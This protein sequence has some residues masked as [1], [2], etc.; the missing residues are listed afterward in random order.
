[1]NKLLTS[2]S[3]IH[4]IDSTNVFLTNVFLEI[5]SKRLSTKRVQIGGCRQDGCEAV[6]WPARTMLTVQNTNYPFIAHKPRAT[7]VCGDDILVA[8]AVA[9]EDAATADLF[10]SLVNFIKQ[11]HR[12]RPLQQIA[13]CL[14]LANSLALGRRSSRVVF[15]TVFIVHSFFLFLGSL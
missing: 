8:V 12:R 11:T 3:S 13:L 10:I 2:L 14:M 5:T 6:V 15:S 7:F 4:E 9:G 1:M